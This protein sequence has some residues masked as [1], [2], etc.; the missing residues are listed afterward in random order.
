MPRR[1]T[2]Y[3]HAI[4]TG[5]NV[6]V[7]SLLISLAFTKL[8]SPN[9]SI[10]LPFISVA[11]VP[12]PRTNTRRSY[13]LGM[14][15]SFECPYSGATRPSPVQSPNDTTLE[16][17]PDPVFSWTLKTS[18]SRP[19][20]TPKPVQQVLGS[21]VWYS[22]PT[23]RRIMSTVLLTQNHIGTYT[24]KCTHHCSGA[25]SHDFTVSGIEGM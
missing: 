9:D 16:N 18:N 8:P 23:T 1:P 3:I 10:T 20:S 24:C 15:I 17:T 19:F 2:L 12:L 22:S 21:N 25:E 4:I 14:N 6:Q 13:P 5:M 7:H 11:N